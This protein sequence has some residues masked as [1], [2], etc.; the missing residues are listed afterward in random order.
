MHLARVTVAAGERHRVEGG[1][2]GERS[3]VAIREGRWEGARLRGT[4]VGAGGDWAVPGTGGLTLLDVRQ[5][6]RT[7]DGA[8]VYVT[9]TGRGDRTRGTYTVAPTFQTGD[10]RYRWLNAVQAVGKGGSRTAGS[11][12]RC[13]RSADPPPT[14]RAPPARPRPGT[15]AAP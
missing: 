8:T 6:L 12:T 2:F 9:Y 1:P 14:P 15:A 5:V 4:V 10:E 11:S 7:D 3:V 13:T